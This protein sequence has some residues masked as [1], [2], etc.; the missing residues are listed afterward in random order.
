MH[1]VD[2]GSAAPATLADYGD[3]WLLRQG[4]TFAALGWQWDVE[5]G[6]GYLSLD[7]PIA[8]NG[9]QSITGLLRDDLP[10][11]RKPQTGPSATLSR[12]TSAAPNIPSPIQPTPATSSPSA[13]RPTALATPFRVPR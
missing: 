7:T 13:T 4:Y 2:G 9:A 8:H 3:A 10:I 11:S 6:H 12:A 5:R 1:I